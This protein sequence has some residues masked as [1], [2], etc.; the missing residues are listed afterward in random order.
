MSDASQPYL[1][2]SPPQQFR[3][4][5]I[6]EST[7]VDAVPFGEIARL[8]RFVSDADVFEI[9]DTPPPS[10]SKVRV[11]RRPPGLVALLISSA[12]AAVLTIAG[13]SAAST[14]VPEWIIERAK[15][16]V[17]AVPVQSSRRAPSPP[18]VRRGSI[19]VVQPGDSLSLI[20]ARYLGDPRKWPRLLEVNRAIISDA[21]DLE[22]GMQLRLPSR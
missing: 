15:V 5:R 14:L 12:V 3:G 2:V 22:V 10:H 11:V 18:P 20:A 7:D 6:V 21:A 4:D 16:A 9:P 13:L 19:Y 1:V 17:R 8:P